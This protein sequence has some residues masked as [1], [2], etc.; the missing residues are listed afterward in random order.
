MA[1][2]LG[3]TKLTSA[4]FDAA[5]RPMFR[6][7]TRLGH[8][9]GRGV[10]ELVNREVLRLL[11]AARR[12]G[13]KAGAIGVCVP[14]IADTKTGRVWAPSIM[15]WER[16]PLREEIRT[17]LA[18]ARLPVILDSDRAACVLGEAWRGAARGCRDA[19][20]L[21]V[22][23][24]IGAGILADGQVLRGAH[25]SAGAIGWLALSRPFHQA[26]ASC[27]D[28]EYHASGAGLAQ[29]ATDWVSQMPD[30]CGPLK[31]RRDLTA[32]DVFAAH[33]DG[34][35]VATHVLQN[36]VE[37]WGAACANLVS[38]FNPEKI[39]FGGG[40]FGPATRFLKDIRAEAKKWAQPVAIRQVKFEASKL[41]GD[42]GLYGA[43][44]LAW[45]AVRG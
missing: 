43:G 4:L 23:T 30:Y 7:G 32:H 17:V 14:G 35:G 9:Q 20:F 38:L 24:G 3:G 12:A 13:L 21:A 16:Y 2:D 5:G 22:G 6:R 25:D 44:Y 37:Y 18:E 41:G 26:Y 31:R 27:G 45:R 34:D 28:F 39:I 15:G 11:A 40:V 10:G 33:A 1:L 19:I 8:R 36:A 42:A 29:V